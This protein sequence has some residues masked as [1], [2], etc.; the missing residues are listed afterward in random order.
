VW[1]AFIVSA[2][3]GVLRTGETHRGRRGLRLVILI[4]ATTSMFY[5]GLKLTV[6]P[7]MILL[8]LSAFTV[9]DPVPA[10]RKRVKAP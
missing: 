5:N 8:A 6:Q 9:V 2:F 4:F 3:L 10:P 7:M 1:I